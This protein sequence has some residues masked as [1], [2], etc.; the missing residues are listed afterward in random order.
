MRPSRGVLAMAVLCSALSTVRARGAEE[1]QVTK[2]SRELKVP[3]KLV[4]ELESWYLK[5]QHR[6]HQVTALSDLEILGALHRQLL[7][8]EVIL[9]PESGAL[10]DTVRF[11]LPTGGG[12]IDLSQVVRGSKGGYRFQ[13]KV[14]KMPDNAATRVFYVSNARTRSVEGEDYGAGCGKM[15]EM[16]TWYNSQLIKTPLQVY[17]TDQRDVSVLAGTWMVASVGDGKLWLGTLSVIDS[18]FPQL[19]CSL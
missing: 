7:D 1:G 18:R 14:L 13:F 6:L 8:L 10:E 2:S 17:A 9:T 11:R 5:E 15:S 4:K 12:E 19:Q 16:T 3:Q